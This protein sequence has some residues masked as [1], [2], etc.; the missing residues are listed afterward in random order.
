MKLD[1]IERLPHARPLYTHLGFTGKSRNT[2]DPR[3]IAPN[4][5]LLP[6]WVVLHFVYALPSLPR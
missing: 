1:S 2:V 3:R 4:P 6:L 5:P